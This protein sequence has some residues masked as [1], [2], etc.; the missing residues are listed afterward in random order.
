MPLS[1]GI[2]DGGRR[3]RGGICPQYSGKNSGNFYVK[4]G[5]FLG[6]KS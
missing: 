5:H 6:Q 3:G 1:I 2:G 4:F